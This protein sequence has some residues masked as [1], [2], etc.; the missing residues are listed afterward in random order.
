MT[1]GCW[2]QTV[3]GEFAIKAR[4]SRHK[5][6]SGGL[7][8]EL[9]HDAVIRIGGEAPGRRAHSKPRHKGHVQYRVAATSDRHLQ[10]VISTLAD[11]RSRNRPC[12]QK[13]HHAA[14]RRARPSGTSPVVASRHSAIRSLRASATIMV[15]RVTPRASAVRA[16]Y[17]LANTLS[18]WCTRKP[19]ASCSIPRR[20]RALPDL[21]RPRSRR[22]LPLSSGTPVRPAYRATALRS[23]VAGE[24]LLYQH[25]G[26]LDA[27]P[28]DPDEQADHRIASFSGCLLQSFKAGPF[29][30]ICCLTKL[31][32]TMSRRSSARVFG[33]RAASSGV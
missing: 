29:T 19:Q 25:I 2:H 6:V 9:N 17:H 26:R 33:G 12:L 10:S 13:G 7:C 3:R 14:A 21:A 5:L 1:S 4:T 8:C 31:R 11:C 22:F 27:N 16:R 30:L 23:R 15:L 20:T 28:D 18:G 32:R 24:N